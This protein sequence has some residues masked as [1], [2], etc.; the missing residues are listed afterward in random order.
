VNGRGRNKDGHVWNVAWQ[1]AVLKLATSC[2]DI[3]K[4]NY[5]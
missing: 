5:V 2:A 3:K 4:L 1:S